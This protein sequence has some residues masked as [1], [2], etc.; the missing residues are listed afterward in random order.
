[1]SLLKFS[2]ENAYTDT[3]STPNDKQSR[4]VYP[5]IEKEV[6]RIIRMKKED[7]FYIPYGVI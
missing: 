7:V 6:I 3:I 4:R 1:M 5:W 2:M